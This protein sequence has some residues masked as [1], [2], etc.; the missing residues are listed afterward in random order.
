MTIKTTLSFTDRHHRF[1]MEQVENGV[2]ATA[3]A[4][5][6]AAI[7]DM[8]RAEEERRLMLGALADVIRERMATP[9]EEYVDEDDV[10]GPA[11]A[12]I[13]AADE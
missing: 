5:V 3:S 1:L 7:E 12:A 2:F 11:F 6:A 13:E 4:G 9:L 8:M 10:F